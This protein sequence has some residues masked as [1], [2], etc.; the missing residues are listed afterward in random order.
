M[1]EFAYPHRPYAQF[2]DDG[3]PKYFRRRYGGNPPPFARQQIGGRVVRVLS[4]EPVEEIYIYGY[5][6]NSNYPEDRDVQQ[7]AW[8]SR[9]NFLAYCYST[10]C[11][12]GEPGF[13]AVDVTEE[14]SQEDFER[15][16]AQE[17]K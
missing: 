7:H 8:Q 9:R 1:T 4:M 6:Y 11:P 14:I 13:V 17:W 3:Q 16:A 5:S 12:H 2:A 15:A 10:M